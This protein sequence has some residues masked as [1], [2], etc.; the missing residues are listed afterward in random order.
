MLLMIHWYTKANYKYMKNYDKNKKSSYIQQ[1][2]A[3]CMDGKCLE[4]CLW[5][6]LN[7]KKYVSI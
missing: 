7:E 1:M 5:M 2:Q 3:S 4:N 6:V